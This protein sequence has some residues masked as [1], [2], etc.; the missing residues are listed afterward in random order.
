MPVPQ[1]HPDLGCAQTWSITHVCRSLLPMTR[2]GRG[3]STWPT[4]SPGWDQPLPQ[5]APAKL[6][7]AEPA[8]PWRQVGGQRALTQ[9]KSSAGPYRQDP[10]GGAL[11]CTTG[12]WGRARRRWHGACFM[13]GMQLCPVPAA[14]GGWMAAQGTSA[15]GARS[16]LW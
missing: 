3:L 8:R 14:Q 10:M 2:P 1:F 4:G 6:S 16:P 7:S 9:G 12:G 13:L 11:L 5:S 15:D